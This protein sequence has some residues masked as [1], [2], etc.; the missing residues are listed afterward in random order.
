MKDNYVKK[1]NFNYDKEQINKI[2]LRNVNDVKIYIE[3][4]L[5]NAFVAKTK[6]NIVK[7][8]DNIKVKIKIKKLNNLF[9]IK[10]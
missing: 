1:H 6:N 7:F 3:D 5:K 8:D 10:K 2:E 9:S 4:I